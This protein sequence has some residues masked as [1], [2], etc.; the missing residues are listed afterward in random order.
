MAESV[1][2]VDDD[3]QLVDLCKGV[4]SAAGLEITTA[5][6]GE[7]ALKALG[8]RGF[9]LVLTDMMLPGKADGRDVLQAAKARDRNIEV[10]I[11]T[12]E[13]SLQSAVATLKDGAADYLV[14]PLDI[15]RLDATVRRCLDHR[16]LRL[17]L[18]SERAVRLE[19]ETAYQ[20]LQRVQKLKE[21]FLARISHEFKT[22]LFEISGSLELIKESL[23]G[24]A[25]SAQK[26]TLAK[27]LRM[28]LSGYARIEKVLSD[29]LL[30]VDLQSKPSLGEKAPVDLEALCRGVC[31]R[32][33]ETAEQK[34]VKISVEFEAGL[35]P[36]V[37]D[38][39]LLD[40]AF[41]HLV[42]NAIVFNRNEGVVVV[43]G[44]KMSPGRV[45]VAVEDTGPG[46]PQSEFAN[47]FDSF[48]Q[49]AN[50]LTRE[51]G[52]L[53]LGLAITRSIVD[54]HGGQITVVS[55]LGSGSTFRVI[56]PSLEESA[57]GKG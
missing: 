5:Y 57:Q 9:D 35:A 27:Y 46:I 43:R 11:M 44:S 53:G 30:F 20:E 41:G 13:P 25:P 49:I 26:D 8:A 54:A 38:A 29:L 39:R 33:R 23:S 22:P 18:T 10:L 6:T 40:R 17:T 34:G 3:E 42:H 37:G 2:V 45:S 16:S 50:Y 19:L 36:A 51:V 14:K 7:Q 52:G 21:S 1:L 28:S 32:L 48:Y 56:L 31:G 47:I 15:D 12:A 24:L 4:L 55:K